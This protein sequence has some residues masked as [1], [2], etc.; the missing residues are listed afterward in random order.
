MEASIRT[1]VC[2]V[3]G[4]YP[5]YTVATHTAKRDGSARQPRASH[6]R[7]GV[8]EWCII[9]TNFIRITLYT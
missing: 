8:T 6:M 1:D 5:S 9:K 7:T 4:L 2:L 3:M